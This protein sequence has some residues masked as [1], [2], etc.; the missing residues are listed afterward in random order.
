MRQLK[1]AHK[2]TTRESQALDK[3]LNE[4]GKISM[5]TPEE[6][7]K[8]AQRI[9]E[10]DQEALDQMTRA[11]LR[12]VVS[13]AKQYQNQ[14][15]SLSDLINEGN[16]GLIKAARRFDETKGFKFISYAVWWIRQSVLQAI[17]ENSRI[18]RMPI[19]KIGSYS[20]INDAHLSFV[21]Q[22][23]R[24]PSDEELSEILG[25]SV[26]DVQTMTR[27]NSRHL[28]LDAPLSG[29]DEGEATMLD[30]MIPDETSEPDL[31]LMAESLREEVAEGMSILSPRETEVIAS[32]YGLNGNEPLN[33]DEIGELY[34]LTRERVRQIKERALRRL[35]K[36]YNTNALKSYLG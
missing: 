28:S 19:N 18:V 10:G 8:L 25:V 23:E 15:L 3:Y 9:R 24:E 7:V 21:Q 30:V 13:V 6:E 20:K 36:A 32:Y 14:G 33:L 29:S 16:V 35:R 31:Q 17:V 5:L 26:K 34:G 1:I 11:N 4:I 2:I 12:F 27:G 22:F